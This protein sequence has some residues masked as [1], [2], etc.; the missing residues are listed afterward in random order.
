MRTAWQALY[1]LGQKDLSAVVVLSHSTSPGGCGPLSE[2]RAT[3]AWDDL[4]GPGSSLLP[5]QSGP[6]A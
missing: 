5:L 2:G 6:I 3:S 1:R 4:G